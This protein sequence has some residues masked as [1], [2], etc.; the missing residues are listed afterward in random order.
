MAL[1]ARG[2][3]NDGRDV[4]CVV[5]AYIESHDHLF[6]GCQ[7]SAMIWESVKGKCGVYSPIYCGPSFWNQMGHS[8]LFRGVLCGLVSSTIVLMLQYVIFRGKGMVGFSNRFVEILG[9]LGQRSWRMWWLVVVL[10]K[11]FL[12]LLR[13]KAI[14]LIL[15]GLVLLWN[16]LFQ[17]NF[18]EPNTVLLLIH[19]SM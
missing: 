5:E 19:T 16:I 1:Q 18:C 15:L 13:I 2:V 4:F 3:T 12:S 17:K 9:L 6:F 7:Y 10:G 8:R 14:P 11:M